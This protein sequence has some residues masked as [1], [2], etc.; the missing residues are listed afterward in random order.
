MSIRAAAGRE[1][2][3][4]ILLHPTSLPGP[5]GMGEIGVE[6]E[7]FADVLAEMEQQVWQMLPVGPTG[8]AD[9]PYQSLSTF[10]GNAMLLCFRRLAAAG[11]V[12]PRRLESFAAADD[13]QVDYGWVIPARQAV[14]QSVCREF[15][16]R[17]DTALRAGFDAFCER[18]RGWLDD[19]ALF[20]AIKEDQ[21]NRPWV[22]WPAPLARREPGALREAAERLQGA[23][24]AAR[25]RQYLFEVQWRELREACA[26]RG[27]LVMGDVPIFVAHDSADVWAHP[28][29]FDL[30]YDGRLQSQAG[31]PPDYF[32]ATGQLW[33]NPLYLW[34][35][36]REGNYAWWVARMRRAF[37]LFDMVRID[38]FRGFE[39]YWEVPGAARTAAGG[40]WVKGPGAELFEALR[41]E[42]G[43]LPVVAEDLGVITPAVEAL[44]DGCGFP[45]MCILQFG[46][47]KDPKA[48][49]YRPDHVPE[50]VVV[51]TGTHDNDTTV[52][53][54]HSQ[55]GA[56]STRTAAD[57]E[58]ERL[59]VCK[60]LRTDGREI[61]WDMIR[62]ALESHARLAMV[63][64][65]DVLGLGS[66]ARMNTPGTAAG[67][68]RWRFRWEDLTPAMRHRLRELTAEAGRA[69]PL[70]SAR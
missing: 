16:R 48:D 62:A 8:F 2:R 41:R 49:E 59:K 58:A 67:N 33:G 10:A 6:A 23:M 69:R 4:G 7:A 22:Q 12:P 19:Y 38:H 57:I 43:P 60:L 45:G 61:H 14:L 66:E 42:L 65:Q 34:E 20:V 44:R 25:I 46:F 3:S 35:R 54:F 1:R 64:L 63:P 53:W 31:V 70:T 17:A 51:Y 37:E 29:L 9:S 36:H 18:H 30:A 68:W 55:P 52:G 26:A 56:G 21:D 24:T 5:Y 39:A 40:R 27:I 11:L 28:R 32:S 13:R 47:G 50:N 15:G